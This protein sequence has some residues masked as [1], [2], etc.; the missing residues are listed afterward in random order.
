MYPPSRWMRLPV[1]IIM[2]PHS[3][4]TWR[5]SSA[6]MLFW[7]IH[8]TWP[9][10]LACPCLEMR[11]LQLLQ[12]PRVS[13]THLL[14]IPCVLMNAEYQRRKILYENV[15]TKVQ[16][17]ACNIFI[18]LKK[19]RGQ[20]QDY[21]HCA[22]TGQLEMDKVWGMILVKCEMVKALMEVIFVCLYKVA[23]F[24]VRYE[25][26]SCQLFVTTYLFVL[27]ANGLSINVL[28]SGQAA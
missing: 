15:L 1:M 13:N 25:V 2:S 9:T 5:S 22:S 8:L 11:L 4:I 19:K 6:S 21:H 28:M 12:L 3:T 20:Y 17:L 7:T 26:M 14:C 24:L 16:I 10:W 18:F 27:Q 23:R